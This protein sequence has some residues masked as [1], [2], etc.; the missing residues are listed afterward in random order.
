[1]PS[2][3]FRKRFL[4]KPGHPL[5]LDRIDPAQEISHEN[6]AAAK[7]ESERLVEAF[8]G[9]DMRFPERGVDIVNIRRKY[10]AAVEQSPGDKRT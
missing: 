3:P 8:E 10:H 7:A 6:K 1:M 2:E 4:V 9:S 5:S